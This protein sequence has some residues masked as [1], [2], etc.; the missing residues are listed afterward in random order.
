M[1]VKMMKLRR[2]DKFQEVLPSSFCAELLANSCE[3]MDYKMVR[4]RQPFFLHYRVDLLLQ[5]VRYMETA[6]VTPRQKRR[7][8]ERHPPVLALNFTQADDFSVNYLRGLIYSGKDVE[9]ASKFVHLLYNCCPKLHRSYVF[10]IKDNLKII[11]QELGITEQC[12]LRIAINMPCFLL[13]NTEKSDKK[14]CLFHRDYGLPVGYNLDTHTAAI[15]PPILNGSLKL[16]YNLL[17]NK[18][19]NEQAEA[20]PLFSLYDVLKYDFS[21]END[22]EQ[23]EDLSSFLIE[24]SRAEGANENADL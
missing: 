22:K 7:E 10:K 3:D 8:V 5:R 14:F 21:Y 15:F 19:K 23:P 11:C 2:H 24:N 20:L 13:W 4:Q 9:G 12:A 6:K 1:L 16:S 17:T 18:P